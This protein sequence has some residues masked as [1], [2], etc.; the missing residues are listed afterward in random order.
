LGAAESGFYPGL[1]LYLTYWFPLSARARSVSWLMM[2]SP[3][4]GL[5]GGPLSG[6]LL[7]LTGVGHLAGWQW[8]FLMEGLPAIIL[9]ASVRFI[10]TEKPRDAMWLNA[11][12][13]E[14]LLTAIETE[15][16]RV[17]TIS[18]SK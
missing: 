14:I 11:T 12:E 2:A 15:G 10:L 9:G 7:S 18:R 3:V 1:I 6:I 17:Q 8:L 5:I 13:R 16:K 4:A